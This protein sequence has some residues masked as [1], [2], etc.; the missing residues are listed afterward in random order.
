M[1]KILT[2]IFNAWKIPELRK[3][4]LFTAFIFVV[5]RLAAHIPVPSVDIVA[6]KDLFARNQLLGLLDIFSGGTLA[7][8]S[9]MALGLNPYINSSIIFQLLTMAIPKLEALQKEGE[10][11]RK[12]INQYTRILTVPF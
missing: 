12:K 7:N 5:F 6:L 1:N 8:F 10:Y 3:R 2:T 4:I 9:I 11:G